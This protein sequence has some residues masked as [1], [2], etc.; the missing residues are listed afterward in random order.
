VTLFSGKLYGVTR[1]VKICRT[2]EQATRHRP[3]TGDELAVSPPTNTVN[4]GDVPANSG[5]APANSV[6]SARLGDQ[7]VVRNM[8]RPR[9]IG[10][11]QGP[12]PTRYGDWEL[13][14]RCI[15]F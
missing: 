12:D 9:E 6:D 14:G 13:R 3:P 1:I 4:S 2:T 11:R 10:G 15:D 7:P 8:D 5:D